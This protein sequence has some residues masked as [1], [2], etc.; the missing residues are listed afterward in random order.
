MVFKVGDILVHINGIYKT[1]VILEVR[2]T[3]Y[4]TINYLDGE[5]IAVLNKNYI[6]RNYRKLT[7]L[8]KAL[9]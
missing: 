8:E 9:K 7:P 3:Y 1:K 5:V 4:L 6:D 2:I